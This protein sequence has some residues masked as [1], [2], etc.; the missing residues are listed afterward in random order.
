MVDVTINN[1]AKSEQLEDGQTITVPTGEIWKVTINSAGIGDQDGQYVVTI[2]GTPVQ[3]QEIN[4]DVDQ[5]QST[6]GEYVVRDGDT[7]G[8]SSTIT[9]SG[10][11]ISGFV[12]N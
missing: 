2:N 12:V 7:I 8:F 3:G 1:A 9:E 10:C 6:S 4:A 11:H 5:A